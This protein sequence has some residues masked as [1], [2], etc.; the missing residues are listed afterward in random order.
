VPT[1]DPLEVIRLATRVLA[2]ILGTLCV[3]SLFLYEDEQGRLQNTLE[4]WW[5]RLDDRKTA[6]MSRHTLFAQQVARS[7]S[8]AMDRVFGPGLIT[9]RALVMSSLLS[10]GVYTSLDGFLIPQHNSPVPTVLFLFGVAVVCVRFGHEGMVLWWAA[11]VIIAWT[12][13]EAIYTNVRYNLGM[14]KALRDILER[15]AAGTLSFL[16]DVATIAATRR[17]L[18]WCSDSESLLKIVAVLGLS[19][20]LAIGAVV[21]PLVLSAA[22]PHG[23]EIPMNVGIA[24]LNAGDAVVCMGVF[25][26]GLLT[27]AHRAAW[28]LVGRLAYGLQ[29]LGVA[30]RNKIAATIGLTL[31]GY[32]VGGIP[33]WLTK[34]F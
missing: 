13:A 8:L 32:A 18:R 22:R 7:S 31:L 21:A 11:L 34:L 29:R 4:R 26:F 19:A 16:F 24:L 10:W 15:L 27:L 9:W 23:I 17:F 1:H 28:P 2:G 14:Q 25:G 20:T 30:P 33:A 12:S 6:A 3:F 5:I